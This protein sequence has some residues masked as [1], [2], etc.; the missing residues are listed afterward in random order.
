MPDIKTRDVV[1]GTIKTL[2]RAAIAGQRMKQSY[3]RTKERAA[4]TVQPAQASPEE[5]A[6]DRITGSVEVASHEGVHQL[7]N[8]GHR[9]V[10]TVKERRQERRQRERPSKRPTSPRPAPASKRSIPARP[11]SPQRPHRRASGTV[12]RWSSF[13]GRPRRE[14]RRNRP[15]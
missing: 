4:E 1:R 8:A 14:K 7:D 12:G 11:C 10:A 13:D 3:I 6:S 9:A 2:D 5:Y 15:S